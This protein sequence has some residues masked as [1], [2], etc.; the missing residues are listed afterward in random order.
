ML[1]VLRSSPCVNHLS[2]VE[3][4]SLLHSGLTSVTN[5]ALDDS[6]W[7][8]SSLPIRDGGLDIRSVVMLTPSAFLA[9]AASTLE[10]QDAGN[11]RNPRG[12]DRMD[13]KRPDGMTL[14]PWSE[15]KSLT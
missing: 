13:E 10:L 3:F 14:I 7:L 1:N 2:L 6:A 4:D 8:Q 15:G 9:S 11:E 5:C 12:L